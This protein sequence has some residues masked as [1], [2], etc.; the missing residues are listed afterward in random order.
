[1]TGPL[2][3]LGGLAV[4]GGLVNTP[5]RPALEH[6]LEPAFEAFEVPM[7]HLPGS[8]TQWLLAVISVG[9]G[10]AGIVYAY[11]RY[12]G[13]RP[14]PVESG[15]LWDRLEHGY[16]V[17]DLYGKT[18]VLPGKAAATSAAFTIDAGIVD[19]AVNGAGWLVTQVG[20]RLRR[21]QT[22]RVRNYGAGIL[23]GAVGLLL[24]LLV[25]GGAF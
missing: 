3:A 22:G 5:F 8:G 6:F 10:V 4:I 13:D 9:A 21:L 2:A 23:L 7:A 20:D 25:G 18:L 11:R 15:P 12:L 16:Y 17:D 19:G 1:M 14:R 24:W